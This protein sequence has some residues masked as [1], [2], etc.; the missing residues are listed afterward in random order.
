MQELFTDHFRKI[1]RVKNIG[2]VLHFF[3]AIPPFRPKRNVSG[4]KQNIFILRTS[5]LVRFLF[6][7]E[8]MNA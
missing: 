2:M 8:K 7:K 1:V 4:D 6:Q 3:V 5:L